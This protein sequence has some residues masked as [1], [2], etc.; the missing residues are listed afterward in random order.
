M[1][2]RRLFVFLIVLAV[3][4]FSPVSLVLG[5][6]IS[7]GQSHA[8]NDDTYQN[9]II[10][11][12][13]YNDIVPGTHVNLI[14]GGF[15]GWLQ[16]NHHAT[17]DIAGGTTR[18]VDAH[19]DGVVSVTE[20]SVT[21]SLRASG[22][23]TVNVSGGSVGFSTHW[24]TSTLSMYG[25]SVGGA[26]ASGNA[27][28]TVFDGSIEGSLRAFGDSIITVN[29][30]AVSGDLYVGTSGIINLNGTGFEVNGQ[31]LS[32]GDKLSD[33]VPLTE[34]IVDGRIEYWRI[35]T[36]TG[37]LAG[38]SALDSTFHITTVRS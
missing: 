19:G 20:G 11:L 22:N 4:T 13:W 7:D 21:D 10:S 2:V 38:G 23:V 36:I 8:I 6:G 16:S 9:E 34:R 25:G 14:D 32:Y 18:V 30:G 27:T 3:S 15:V 26:K 5:I 28:I 29:G 17:I 31:A 33:F 37:T 12:D 1:K 35:G 24:G